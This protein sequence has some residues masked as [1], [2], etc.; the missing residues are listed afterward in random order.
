MDTLSM[1]LKTEKD[2]L[3]ATFFEKHPALVD[4]WAKSAPIIV[5]TTVPW[6]PVAGNPAEGP[7]ALV[8]TAGVHLK[9]QT[10]F[11]M[12]DSAGDS[13][14]RVIPS[15][16]SAKDLTITHNYYNHGD[17]DADVNVVFPIERLNELCAEGAVGHV[18][19]RHFSFM[20][21]I[22]GEHLAGLIGQTAPTV[23]AELKKDGVRA[24]FLTPA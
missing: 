21:H 19:P 6:S 22:E 13:S 8:T 18:A 2:K 1:S 20:G 17:A 5:N 23:A 9:S 7:V 3:V 14:F 12:E 15:S 16:S 11:D 24:V 4:Q 10:P